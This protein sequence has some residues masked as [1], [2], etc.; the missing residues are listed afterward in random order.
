MVGHTPAVSHE[1]AVRDTELPE[2]AQ[3]WAIHQQ[4]AM[5]VQRG[6]QSYQR[7]ANV[8]SGEPYQ[9]LS[10]S[11]GVTPIDSMVTGSKL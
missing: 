5:S 1:C 2:R 6:T 9:L 8:H 10:E 7:E 3:W 4:S 11:G